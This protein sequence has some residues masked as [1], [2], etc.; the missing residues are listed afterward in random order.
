M[1]Y[2]KPPNLLSSSQLQVWSND[3]KIDVDQREET[4]RDKGCM[5]TI[6]RHACALLGIVLK[7]PKVFLSASK[8]GD[9][10]MIFLI[11][12]FAFISFSSLQKI[13]ETFYTCYCPNWIVL[14]G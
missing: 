3:A 11:S 4:H 1:S 5:D 8:Q 10:M 12:F 13:V 6:G 7:E 9:A 2:S 14:Y